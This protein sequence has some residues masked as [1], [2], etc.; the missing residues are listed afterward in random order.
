VKIS[1]IYAC[2]HEGKLY[3][4]E[5]L[6]EMI[7]GTSRRSWPPEYDFISALEALGFKIV[8]LDK[9]PDY[10]HKELN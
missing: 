8:A 4:A 7:S 10:W 5:L 2:E 9:R 6:L 3:P 1:V